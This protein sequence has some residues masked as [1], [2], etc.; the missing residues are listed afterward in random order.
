M[1]LELHA[2]RRKKGRLPEQ[3]DPRQAD[4]VHDLAKGAEFLL[5]HVLQ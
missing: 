5:L 4:H 2:V 3:I 1:V